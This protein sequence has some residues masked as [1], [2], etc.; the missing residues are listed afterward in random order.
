VLCTQ[1][2]AQLRIIPTSSVDNFSSMKTYRA[3]WMS[4][5]VTALGLNIAV[6]VDRMETTGL[7]R[8]REEQH[9]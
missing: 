5:V 9:L 4:S 8:G 7:I 1:Y 2:S 3:A 6:R